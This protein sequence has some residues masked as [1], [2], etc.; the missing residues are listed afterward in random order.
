MHTNA[1]YDNN[2]RL[3]SPMVE[4]GV[5][6]A[7][8]FWISRSRAMQSARKRK[9]TS[10]RW[11]PW[12]AKMGR[13]CEESSLCGKV[14]ADF[15]NIFPLVIVEAFVAGSKAIRMSLGPLSGWIVL[16][17]YPKYRDTSSNPMLG[18]ICCLRFGSQTSYWN[19]PH[20]KLR[21]SM[22]DWQVR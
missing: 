14:L 3:A 17:L 5:F 7:S 21:H 4:V 16:I 18:V 12:D 2:L 22:D 19:L 15:P 9:A 1:Y 13:S 8:H 20:F 11:R 10:S 6:G